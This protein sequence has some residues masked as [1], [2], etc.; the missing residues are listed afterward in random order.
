MPLMDSPTSQ[1]TQT[2]DLEFPG[3][4]RAFEGKPFTALPLSARER[5]FLTDYPGKIARFN[6]GSQEL[7]IRWLKRPTRKLHCASDSFRA[8]DYKITPSAVRADGN[9][10]LWSSFSAQRERQE[11]QVY[12]RNFDHDGNSWIHV[13]GWYWSAILSR[14]GG[15]WWAITVAET[16]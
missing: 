12:E 16:K 14:S 5:Q 9:G 7:I 15:P 2:K 10:E 8:L 11:L 6:D 13:S 3:W 1:T 4:P